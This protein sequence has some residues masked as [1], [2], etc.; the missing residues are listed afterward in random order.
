MWD[1]IGPVLI[2]KMLEG[3]AFRWPKPADG[4]IRLSSAQ[5]SALVEGLGWR[6][7]RAERRPRPAG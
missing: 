1:Q 2:Y 6:A 4:M 5:F 3:T 7:V